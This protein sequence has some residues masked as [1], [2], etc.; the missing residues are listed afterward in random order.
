MMTNIV[1]YQYGS[2]HDVGDDDEEKNDTGDYHDSDGIEKT[3][4]SIRDDIHRKKNSFKWALPVKL[5]P[6]P[7]P[8][9]SP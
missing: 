1:Q 5:S 3:P 4:C 2:K 9:P 7:G 6:P 8:P